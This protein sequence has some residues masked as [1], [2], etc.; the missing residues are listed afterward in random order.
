MRWNQ[1]SFQRDYVRARVQDDIMHSSCW[2]RCRVS[3]PKKVAN[4]PRLTNFVSL[5][6]LASS[7]GR[8][9]LFPCLLPCFLCY[10]LYRQDITPERR[11]PPG[12]CAK[13]DVLFLDF[14]ILPVVMPDQRHILSPDQ[15]RDCVARDYFASP[16]QRQMF[17][18][19]RQTK[20]GIYIAR[21]K[22]DL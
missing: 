22:A 14:H 6:C 5:V 10:S 13:V 8:F 2:K 7:C 11:L 1:Y 18:L 12:F 21:P 15:R 3:T 4:L 20:G 16:D 17:R 9:V 19:Y